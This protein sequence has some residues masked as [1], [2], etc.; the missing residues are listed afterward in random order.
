MNLE[1]YIPAVSY[2]APAGMIAVLMRALMHRFVLFWL[3]T[4][5]GTAAHE[6]CHFV[7]GALTNAKLRG[8]SLWPTRFKDGYILGSVTFANL[9]W[10]NA[11]LASL[12]PL[13][14][15][16]LTLGYAYLHTLDGWHFEPWDLL[17]WYVLAGMM[18]SSWPS[19][20]DWRLS[21]RSWPLVLA[22]LFLGYLF[23]F[24]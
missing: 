20:I 6:M 1:P 9:R 14:L 3:L 24:R 18:L 21:I 15:L 23:L 12:A 22:T 2:L 4:L 13:L 8:L 19:D 16:P 17:R 5:P 7:G 10:Y 11:A